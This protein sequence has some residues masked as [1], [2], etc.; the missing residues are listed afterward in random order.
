MQKANTSMIWIWLITLDYRQLNTEKT[1]LQAIRYSQQ[2][3]QCFKE[4]SRA[5]ASMTDLLFELALV[6]WN[7]SLGTEYESK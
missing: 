7:F 1:G 2:A 4:P 3:M 5:S 6:Q